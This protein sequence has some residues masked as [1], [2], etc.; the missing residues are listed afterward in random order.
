MTTKTEKSIS[1]NLKSFT[2]LTI[3]YTD[4]ADLDKDGIM[5][6]IKFWGELLTDVNETMKDYTPVVS[7]TAPADVQVLTACPKCKGSN[8]V[9]TTGIGQASG[10]EWHA[11]DCQDC[12]TTRNGQE[13]PTR[14]F[15]NKVQAS[16][17]DTTGVVDDTDVPF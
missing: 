7:T 17:S 11:M 2:N 12:K 14:T 6:D 1:I 10:K 9:Y 4:I 13:Y 8:L 3:P 5:E 16:V 15:I